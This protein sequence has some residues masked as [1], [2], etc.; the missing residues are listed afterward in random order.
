LQG[1][2]TL[3]GKINKKNIVK[4]KGDKNPIT[5]TGAD[6]FFDWEASFSSGGGAG[7]SVIWGRKEGG[8]KTFESFSGKIEAGK[9]KTRPGL[10][11]GG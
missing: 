11:S 4:F 5:S 3:G 8:K 10:K 9:E 7:V 6:A 1:Q 2:L